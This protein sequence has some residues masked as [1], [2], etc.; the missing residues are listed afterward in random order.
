MPPTNFSIGELGDARAP[1]RLTAELA[2]AVAVGRELERLGSALGVRPSDAF[3]A[4]V[5]SAIATEPLPA[6][7][8]VFGHAARAMRARDVLRALADSW[9]VAWTGGRPLNVRLQGLVLVVMVAMLVAA[10]GG[11]ALVAAA[12]WLSQPSPPSTPHITQP[13][14]APGPSSTAT[15]DGTRE[16]R[17]TAT[18]AHSPSRSPSTATVSPSP[19]SSVNPGSGATPHPTATPHETEEPDATSLPQPTETPDDSGSDDG[20]SEAGGG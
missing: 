17:P 1:V 3:V 20:G 5:M 11:S 6:P 10:I 15:P 19:E 16:A 13:A 4:A 8:V 12:G 9:H 18:P 14:V 7:L 2:E